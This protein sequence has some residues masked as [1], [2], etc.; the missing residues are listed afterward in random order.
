MPPGAASALSPAIRE[1]VVRE[2]AR[3]AKRRRV[4]DARRA[5]EY[6]HKSMGTEG[7]RQAD[8]AAREQLRRWYAD[9]VKPRLMELQPKDV[10][11]VIEVSRAYARQIVTGQIPHRRHFAP[12]AKLAGVPEPKT[13]KLD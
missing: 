1:I 8:M 7:R 11:H 9:Q 6:A 5:W 2:E 10:L 13:L 4:S 12:L 3:S